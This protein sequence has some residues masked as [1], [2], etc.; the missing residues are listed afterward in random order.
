MSDQQII[1]GRILRRRDVGGIV[2]IDVLTADTVEK[3]VVRKD[4]LETAV[5]EKIKELRIDDFC[6]VETEPVGED[7][8][9][10]RVIRHITKRNRYFWSGDQVETV[11]AYALILGCLRDFL[12]ENHYTE[13]QLP[14]IHSGD[15]K[16]EAFSLDFFGKPAR[17]TSSNALFMDVYAVQMQKVFSL[18]RCFRAEKSRT[19]RHLAEFAMLEA[20]AMNRTLEDSMELLEGMVKFVMKRLLGSSCARLCPLDLQSL[21]EG[22]FEVVEYKTLEEKYDL[23]GKGLGKHEKDISSE[24]PVFVIHFPHRIASWTAR[25]V[26]DRFSAS[27]NLLLPEIGEVAEGAER[28][29][30]MEKMKK[31]LK[32]SGMEAQLGWYPE[33]M[34]YSDFDLAG[35]GLGVERLAMWLLGCRNI[36][37]VLPIYRDTDFSERKRGRWGRR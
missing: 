10:K 32:Y 34:P 33:M 18:Q 3:V 26:D 23:K 21:I 9:L 22:E 27:F 15:V 17:L 36:R 29:T 5:F 30:H 25:P 2:F 12:T 4:Q 28:Q 31:K 37:E 14:A 13:V 19:S 24:K 7:R 6:E 8:I 16:N 20:A 11:R 1:A 35:F